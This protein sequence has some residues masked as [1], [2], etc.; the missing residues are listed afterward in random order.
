MTMTVE[1][2]NAHLDEIMKFKSFRH[3]KIL[4]HQDGSQYRARLSVR[5]NG[6][7]GPTRLWRYA[8]MYSLLR[9]KTWIDSHLDGDGGPF[10]DL[11]KGGMEGF[12]RARPSI[13]SLG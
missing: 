4:I 11:G 10:P 8:T 6:P 13:E 5:K 12:S 7:D 1:Q 2:I 9:I 3:R